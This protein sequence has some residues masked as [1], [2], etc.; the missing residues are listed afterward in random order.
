MIPRR[1]YVVERKRGKR[2]NYFYGERLKDAVALARLKLG[3]KFCYTALLS[4]GIW[5]AHLDGER[6]VAQRRR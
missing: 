5:D 4:A 1:L 6:L 2:T 3:E